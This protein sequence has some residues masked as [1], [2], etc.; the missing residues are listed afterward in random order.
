M[1]GGIGF[2]LEVLDELG[3]VGAEEIE[4]DERGRFGA[5]VE[6]FDDGVGGFVEGVAGME[7]L[8][9]LA[10]G[11]EED[12][13][14]GDQADDGARVKVATGFLVR[15]EVDLFYF[16]VVNVFVLAEDGGEERLAGDGV[17]A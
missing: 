3:F 12:G 14:F 5:G 17:A 8:E 1:R 16:D 6:A 4:A 10:F 2:S 13:A 15:R 11:L 9:G 7:D